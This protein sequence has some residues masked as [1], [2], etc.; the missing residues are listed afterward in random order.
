MNKH[1]K[2]IILDFDDTLAFTTNRDFN[3][4]KPNKELIEKT[5][6]L[7]DEGWQIDI[8]TAR[9]SIS[10]ETRREAREKYEFEMEQWLLEHN[11]KYHSLSFDKPLAAYYVDDKG[12]S[13]EDFINTEIQN[14][15][16][17]LS[18]AD[19]YTDGRLVHKTDKR[20]HDVVEWFNVA[21]KV[22]VIVPHV[23]RVVGETITMEYVEHDKDFFRNNPY[24]A[25]A[26]IQE[27]LDKFKR[28]EYTENTRK[29]ST[30]YMERIRQHIKD[31][32][33]EQDVLWSLV[34]EELQ[35]IFW[36]EESFSHGDFGITNMLFDGW[37]N[38][39]LIDPIPEVFGSTEL[40]IAK[41]IASLY[42]NE[43][44][45]ELIDIALRTLCTYNKLK[46]SDINILVRCELTRVIK[47][48]P[49][50]EFIIG[51]IQDVY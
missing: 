5:N 36:P 15:E 38:L 22:D 33:I 31:C 37:H 25:L 1:H 10:C 16:G 2:R 44:E 47:Y 45:K 46:E 14:L 30:G 23:D 42:I 24:K 8:F 49:D 13:P 50:K 43:Y 48:H 21:K 6:R 9:G 29:F 19:I 3:N 41:F 20:A 40:D 7:Y 39:T 11:V 27:T 18:G 51:L 32:P 17:G 12:I 35:L 26:L 4:A 34:W 28:I